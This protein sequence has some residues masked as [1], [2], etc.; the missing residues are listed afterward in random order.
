ALAQHRTTHHQPTTSIAWGLWANTTAMT[1]H[2]TQADLARL[3]GNGLGPISTD[4]GTALLDAAVRAGRPALAAS[5]VHGV[6]RGDV[7]AALR[8]LV[9]TARRRETAAPG[10]G[11]SLAERL[12]PLTGPQRTTFLIGQVRE[13]VAQVLGH[14]D[15]ASI[16]QEQSFQ[17]LGFD[18]LTAVELRNRLST[19]AGERLPATVVFDHPTPHA[20]AA[21]LLDR[22]V[23]HP[24]VAARAKV[25]ELDVFLAELALADEDRSLITTHLESLIDRWRDRAPNTPGG[26]ESEEADLDS[27]S[28]E[29]L[30]RLVDTSRKE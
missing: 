13:Q 17:D 2:L 1:N 5:A 23:P 15:P 9:R 19:L 29:E 14:D 6:A 7:P 30:F 28:D 8:D 16:G 25:D 20:L 24:H 4:A 27:A 12:R 21:L 11:G 22:L 3:T 10:A 26:P 18:S